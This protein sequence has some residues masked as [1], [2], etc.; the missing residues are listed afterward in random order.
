[1]SRIRPRTA[2]IA[3]IVALDAPVAFVGAVN[4]QVVN[5]TIYR[6]GRWALRILQE[7][8]DSN[9]LEVGDNS[10][11]NNIVVIDG[12]AQ[13]LADMDVI[14]TG[15]DAATA[16]QQ[17]GMIKDLARAHKARANAARDTA[18]EVKAKAREVKDVARAIRR[19]IRVVT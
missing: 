12:T 8:T 1:M 15:Y 11:R 19:T 3:G 16:A 17:R 9:F 5:N 4:S 13:A 6:P 10:F 14:I 18:R 7:T 2:T